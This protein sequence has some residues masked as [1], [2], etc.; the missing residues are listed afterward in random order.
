MD[1]VS[2]QQVLTVALFLGVLGVF[3]LAVRLKKG[4]IRQTLTKGRR[5][6]VSE[7]ASLGGDDRA[8]LMEVDGQDFLVVSTRK[9]APAITALPPRK[10]AE[11]AQ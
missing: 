2:P 11:V 1:I 4:P 10:D 5:I 9:S 7:V 3:W 8:I 6:R